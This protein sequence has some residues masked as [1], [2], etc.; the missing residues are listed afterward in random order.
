MHENMQNFFN[1]IFTKN[2]FYTS[3]VLKSSNF[4]RLH[5]F[6]LRIDIIFNLVQGDII[7]GC[8]SSLYR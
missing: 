7:D 8:V 4:K 2:V 6:I 1:Q 3:S 5:S